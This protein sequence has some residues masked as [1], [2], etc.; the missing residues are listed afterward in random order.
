MKVA[1]TDSTFES[2]DIE[3]SILEPMGCQVVGPYSKGEPDTLLTLVADADCV[4]TQFATVDARVIGSMGRARAIVRYGIGVDNVALEAARA[5]GIPVCNVPDYCIDEVADHTLGLILALT[6]QLLAHRD[7]VRSG[8]WGSGAPLHAMHALKQRTVGLIG[9]GRIGR[10]V[11]D[12]LRAFQ[13]PTIVF[14]PLVPRAEIEARGCR[15]ADWEE[16][17]RTADVMSL[18]CPSHA[19][20]RRMIGQVALGTMKPGA[21]LINV[22]RGDLVDTQALIAA[23]EAGRLAG[24]GLDVCDPEPVDPHSPLL[25]MDQVILTPHVASASVPAVTKLRST[26][27]EI[28]AKALRGERLPNVVNGVIA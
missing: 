18:H 11:G 5:R 23:L 25:K 21:L 6:R 10:A 19:G 17:L 8:R 16:L 15:A 2:L 20:T 1:V 24:A 9:F 12:R 14:D 27:A 28:A 4:L 26:A 22:A 3:R 7:H 13:C